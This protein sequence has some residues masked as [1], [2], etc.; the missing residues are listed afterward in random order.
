MIPAKVLRAYPPYYTGD[1]LWSRR[2][3]LDTCPGESLQVAATLQDTTGALEARI[4]ARAARMGIMTS[5]PGDLSARFAHGELPIFTSTRS[6]HSPQMAPED[7]DQ[8]AYA[9]FS[10]QRPGIRVREEIT[11]DDAFPS[12]WDFDTLYDGQAGVGIEG[13]LPNDYKFQYLG[14]VYR[15]LTTG[16]NEYA[17]QATGWV[18]LPDKDVVGSR[19][20]P[21]FSGP[22]NGGWTT[23]GGPLLRLK[24]H[25]VDLFVQPTGVGPGTILRTGDMFS[26]A[27]AIMPPLD[28]QIAIT[29]T[30]PS[31]ARHTGGGLANRVGYFYNPGDN[32]RMNE[33]GLWSV[34]VRVQHAGLCSG[35]VTIPAYPAGDVLGSDGG[36]FWFYVVP[37]A[38]PQLDIT[39]PAPGIIPFAEDMAPV[40]ISG[41]LPT[42]L[43]E[44]AVDYTI[45]MPGLILEHGQA[46]ISEDT[47]QVIFDPGRLRQDFPN[48]D[49]TGWDSPQR[50]GLADTFRIG[51]LL[52][53]KDARNAPVLRAN[54]LTLINQEISLAAETLEQRVFLPLI[55]RRGS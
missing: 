18:H 38:A 10:A 11:E 53:G 26:F 16:H 54:S 36:R 6:G 28:S 47:Y 37:Q 34:D 13:D 3:V 17:G 31:G 35:G 39:A 44:A 12:Y 51:L 30:A 15:D 45:T 20:M 55:R 25:D 27:G 19:V 21:P 8:L 14:A 33:A 7:V 1:I 4:R 2:E 40:V 9:Y 52:H 42:S 32:F 48:L 29:V 46:T 50:A 23:E 22:G 43:A 5:P 24:D 49:L 41:T